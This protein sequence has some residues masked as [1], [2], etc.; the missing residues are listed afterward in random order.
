MPN[1]FAST[2]RGGSESSNPWLWQ[3]PMLSTQMSLPTSRRAVHT[4][5]SRLSVR[6]YMEH[7]ALIKIL[8][9]ELKLPVI[10]TISRQIHHFHRCGEEIQ[11]LN[12]VCVHARTKAVVLPSILAVCRSRGADCRL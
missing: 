8:N 12:P 4:L 3:R 1:Q 10:T 9:G 2:G 7:N 6:E 5:A 11:I